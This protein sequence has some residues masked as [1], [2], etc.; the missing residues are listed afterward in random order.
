[1]LL[2]SSVPPHC[3]KSHRSSYTGLYPSE[4]K[5]TTPCRMTGVTFYTELYP[6]SPCTRRNAPL[7]FGT[8]LALA[9]QIP[10]LTKS[11][12]SPLCASLFLSKSLP[13][14]C[15]LLSSYRPRYRP[16]TRRSEHPSLRRGPDK[17]CNLSHFTAR[18][19]SLPSPLCWMRNAPL[20][21]GTASALT[22]SLPT[23]EARS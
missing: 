9:A 14:R 5:N 19:K 22:K 2:S 21:F 4:D 7:I 6:Q 13:N 11:L 18:T 16:C 1:M 23:G 17:A 8:A 15:V 12:P 20:I 3:V 10:A